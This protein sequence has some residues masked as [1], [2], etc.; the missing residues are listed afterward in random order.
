[1]GLAQLAEHRRQVLTRKG[2][3]LT[4]QNAPGIL[5]PSLRLA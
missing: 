3:V 1:M 2:S 4:A 5:A